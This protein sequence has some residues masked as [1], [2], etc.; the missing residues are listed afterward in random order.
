M[1]G[2]ETLR[3]RDGWCTKNVSLTRAAYSACN[4]SMIDTSPRTHV[5]PTPSEH[6]VI[7]AADMLLKP[8]CAYIQTNHQAIRCNDVLLINAVML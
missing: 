6:L 3:F 8:C 4:D 7:I 1:R 2:M 5:A